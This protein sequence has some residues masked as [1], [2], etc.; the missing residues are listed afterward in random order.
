MSPLLFAAGLVLPTPPAPEASTSG[1]VVEPEHEPAPQ[2]PTSGSPLW[3]GSEQV[4]VRGS[5]KGVRRPLD[6]HDAQEQVRFR[7]LCEQH[8]APSAACDPA[9]LVLPDPADIAQTFRWQEVA[10]LRFAIVA[11]V[12]RQVHG[13]VEVFEPWPGDPD[14]LQHVCFA[15]FDPTTGLI[16]GE[17][18]CFGNLPDAFYER[19]E[20]NS[21]GVWSGFPSFRAANPGRVKPLR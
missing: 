2:S 16:D 5:V 14:R 21:D 20:R 17:R 19:W 3:R 4:E 6:L 18:R 1:P 10:S 13:R 9:D 8:A 7:D 15:S 12:D 11:P